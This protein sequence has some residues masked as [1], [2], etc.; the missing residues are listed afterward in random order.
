LELVVPLELGPGALGRSQEGRDRAG[1][2][3]AHLH[4]LAPRPVSADYLYLS[5]A[6]SQGLGQQFDQR[7]V[8]LVLDRWCRDADLQDVPLQTDDL[9]PAGPRHYVDEDDRRGIS[10]MRMMATD[11]LLDHA[12]QPCDQSY[13][14]CNMR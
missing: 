14:P 2:Y 6:Y 9:A 11:C 1:I 5:A 8:R 13:I 10:G 12:A 4:R 3:P 7:P